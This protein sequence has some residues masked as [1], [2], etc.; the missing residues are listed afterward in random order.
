MWSVFVKYHR[1]MQFGRECGDAAAAAAAD[2]RHIAALFG[3]G[4]DSLF[5][6]GVD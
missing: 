4:A 1:I 6:S 2:A 5:F 3:G